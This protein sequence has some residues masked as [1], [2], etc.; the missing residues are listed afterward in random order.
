MKS[1]DTESLVDLLRPENDLFRL[2][3]SRSDEMSFAFPLDKLPPHVR[4]ALLA[5]PRRADAVPAFLLRRPVAAGSSITLNAFE[6][7]LFCVAYFAVS[8]RPSSLRPTASA[9]ANEPR[10]SDT[11][12]GNFVQRLDNVLDQYVLTG[13]GGGGPV[14]S[15]APVS[16]Q[17]LF[18]RVFIKF[19]DFVF[20]NMREPVMASGSGDKSDAA[21]GGD[22][23][24]STAAAAV[25]LA[26]GGDNSSRLRN[27]RDAARWQHYEYYNRVNSKPDA[28]LR[29]LFL[30]IMLL[31]WTQQNSVALSDV[32]STLARVAAEQLPPSG[33]PPRRALIR[34]ADTAG[35]VT[36]TRLV[37]EGLTTIVSYVVDEV[38]R[39]ASLQHT[40]SQ[41]QQQQSPQPTPQPTPPQSAPATGALDLAPLRRFGLAQMQRPLFHFF[42]QCFWYWSNQSSQTDAKFTKML[43]LWVAFVRPWK[44]KYYQRPPHVTA[45]A[46]A[47]AAAD[48]AESPPRRAKSSSAKAAA[49][50]DSAG[51]D[52]GEQSDNSAV[53]RADIRYWHEY[54]VGNLAFYTSLGRDVMIAALDFDYGSS[55]DR[56]ML[57]RI[58]RTMR[59]RGLFDT[60]RRVEAALLEPTQP[61]ASTA[62]DVRLAAANLNTVQSGTYTDYV[63]LFSPDGKEDV[64]RLARAVGT[65]TIRDS[66]RVQHTEQSWWAL[67]DEPA[68]R[69]SVSNPPGALVDD[70]V[71]L[72]ALD[73]T[74]RLNN[75]AEPA[76]LTPSIVQMAERIGR[77][78]AGSGDFDGARAQSNALVPGMPARRVPYRGDP[79]QRPVTTYEVR[80]LVRLM[81][82]VAVFGER[83]IGVRVPPAVRV[84]ARKSLLTFLALVALAI[85]VSFQRQV[86]RKAE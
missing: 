73:V 75:A 45:W 25:A 76:G 39:L 70:L 28:P 16:R 9:S 78:A 53:E 47:A 56:R 26:V 57:A 69:K 35:F 3:L 86:P 15:A 79:W 66:R 31:F 55:D 24:S 34:Y 83:R 58:L 37:L 2:L 32:R 50:A 82:R 84:L 77:A 18:D 68:P 14:P 42:H 12:I 61:F 72:F 65:V 30:D 13:G 67:W 11:V 81:Y 17:R 19:V 41:Q 38:A 64:E 51:D 85:F 54:V 49:D 4:L 1:R 36:P 5:S 60:M 8:T 62:A 46:E 74:L 23:A 20:G 71:S 27:K 7:F 22:K 48:V 6:Y 63:P 44:S 29:V 40:Q 21:G 59:F 10:P 52:D 33:L 43:S 80:W